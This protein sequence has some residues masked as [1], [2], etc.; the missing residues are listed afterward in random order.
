MAGAGNEVMSTTAINDGEAQQ[1]LHGQ[2]GDMT[3]L[4]G[5]PKLIRGWSN[6][7]H[8]SFIKLLMI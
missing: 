2:K 1:Q 6:H 7:S 5:R 4:G 8:V 3:G